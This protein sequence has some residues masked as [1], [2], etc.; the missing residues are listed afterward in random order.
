[1][2]ETGELPCENHVA[3]AVADVDQTVA[4]LESRS[5]TVEFSP[6]NYDWGRSAYL[7]DPE[8]RLVEIQQER[9]A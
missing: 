4:E 6:P 3:F 9:D 2:P 7:R 5:L 1:M 8:G